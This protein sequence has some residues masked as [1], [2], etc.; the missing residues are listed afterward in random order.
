MLVWL[1]VFCDFL[2]VFRAFRS[3]SDFIIVRRYLFFRLLSICYLC[4]MWCIVFNLCVFW[5]CVLVFVNLNFIFVLLNFRF[6]SLSVF[7]R[8]KTLRLVSF[9]CVLWLLLSILLLCVFEIY[10]VVD[11]L[12]LIF[13]LWRFFV[14]WLL[15][16][17]FSLFFRRRRKTRT[18]SLVGCCFLDLC[19]MCEVVCVG[20][21]VICVC[22]CWGV[23]WVWV[24][25]WC[26][27]CWWVVWW[28]WCLWVSLWV[29][30]WVL[31]VC[32]YL[33]LCVCELCGVCVCF[34]VVLCVLWCVW[35]CCEV[36][37]CVLCWWWWV[38]EV[39]WLG[40]LGR[41][42]RDARM[43]EWMCCIMCDDGLGWI[44]G[45]VRVWWM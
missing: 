37:M 5:V 30:L 3:W 24:L 23:N 39:G 4:F 32:V 45:D 1:C 6:R 22:L 14:L 8:L 33:M 44:Y 21:I 18:A 16:L 7:R 43:R 20:V 31:C 12:F 2:S 41:G 9:R 11:I 10:F 34:F 28:G 13:V 15:S 38:K 17:T 36:W 42:T 25:L 29:L 40:W 26:C 27:L 35:V 19:L